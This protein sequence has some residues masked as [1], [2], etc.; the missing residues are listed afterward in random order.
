MVLLIPVAVLLVLGPAVLRAVAFPL[1]FALLAVPFGEFLVPA[2]MDITA[3]GS[4][5]LLQATGVPVY[6]QGWL[7]SIPQG[8]FLVAEACSGIR[9]LMAA[10]TC[11]ILFGYF[12]F[13]SVRKRI[14]FIVFTVFLTVLANVMRAY[15]II[16]LARLTDMRLAVGVDHFIYGWF[17]FAILVVVLFAV[18]LK[19]AD[20]APAGASVQPAES[21]AMASADMEPSPAQ[22]AARG[23]AAGPAAL[24]G[25]LLVTT[26]VLVAGPLALARLQPGTTGEAALRL[27]V[28]VAGAPAQAAAGQ[29]GWLS[30]TR[31]GG[32]QMTHRY[33]ASV[34]GGI[35][36]HVIRG[37]EEAPRP[38]LGSLRQYLTDEVTTLIADDAVPL[39]TAPLASYRRMQLEYQGKTLLIG[40]WFTVGGRQ[41]ANPVT[42]KFMESITILRGE[43]QRPALIAVALD[44]NRLD[45]PGETLQQIVAEVAATMAA[46][47]AGDDR[48]RQAGR[49]DAV[50]VDTGSQG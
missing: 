28:T 25:A 6:R 17:L 14:Y 4:V 41:T 42:A 29:A 24:P 44:T 32:G 15:I 5:L 21:V 9:Y 48:P 47:A 12:F 16:Q 11:A 18:G 33:Y 7:I 45:M 39:Q 22:A 8:D 49:C 34:P 1:G 20:G 13:S 35:E 37:S 3:D 27:P 46:C 43:Y 30:T 40:Y 10:T 36:L 26:I 50:T 19:F 23:Q 38:D 31:A 2:L